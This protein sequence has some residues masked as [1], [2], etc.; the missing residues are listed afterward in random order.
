[1]Y[2]WLLDKF[3]GERTKIKGQIDSV[4]Y[5]GLPGFTTVYIVA[6]KGT[7][8]PSMGRAIDHIGWRSIGT[9][10][11]TKAMLEGKKV[12]LTSQPTSA[13]SAER[14]VDQFL[15]RRRSRRHAHRARR[16]SRP[17]ARRVSDSLESWRTRD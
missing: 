1:M 9:I 5:A 13:Q 4:K 15:L 6:A 8:V 16:T 14:P 3:G 2:A 7:S 10:A 11:E 12:E 17:E